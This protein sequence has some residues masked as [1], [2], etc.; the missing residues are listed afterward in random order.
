MATPWLL[1]PSLQG[2]CRSTG[3]GVLEGARGS[4]S[5]VFSR[6]LRNVLRSGELQGGFGSSNECRVLEGVLRSLLCVID[7]PPPALRDLRRAQVLLARRGDPRLHR[8]RGVVHFRGLSPAAAA[9]RRRRRLR[10]LHH[11]RRRGAPACTRS[12]C[13]RCSGWLRRSSRC[14]PLRR[15]MIEALGEMFRAVLLSEV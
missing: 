1:W 13:G 4:A 9:G 12:R 5:G 7:P 2:P 3:P 6:G 10:R 14:L 8:L 15:R 11:L